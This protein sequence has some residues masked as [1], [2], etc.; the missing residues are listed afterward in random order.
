MNHSHDGALRV[1]SKLGLLLASADALGKDTRFPAISSALSRSGIILSPA[2][3]TGLLAGSA[4]NA[5]D[6]AL[7]DS[8]CDFFGVP[9][10]YL[11]DDAELSNRVEAQLDLLASLRRNRVRSFAVRQMSEVNAETIQRIQLLLD[12]AGEE[13]VPA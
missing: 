11:G 6:P 13:A 9:A 8:L 5:A 4:A 3:W 12:E 10:G 1:A 7:L 2:A